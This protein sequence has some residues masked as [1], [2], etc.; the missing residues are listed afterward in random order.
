M[1]DSYIMYVYFM[2]CR[3]DSWES[4]QPKW[5]ETEKVLSHFKVELNNQANCNIKAVPSKKR[6]KDLKNEGKWKDL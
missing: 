4:E 1:I 6:K 2:Y 5:T 3:V